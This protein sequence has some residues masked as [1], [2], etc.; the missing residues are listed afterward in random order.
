MTACPCVG[1]GVRPCATCRALTTL[2]PC[3]IDS[4]LVGAR[5]SAGVAVCVIVT[6]RAIA[7][8][9]LI[10]LDCVIVT[11]RATVRPTPTPDDCVIVCVRGMFVDDGAY[12]TSR[13]IRS[14]IA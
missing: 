9:K 8:C 12:S 11:P 2:D 1:L 7:C 14:N 10:D 13:Q 5:P 4:A 6:A 3:V